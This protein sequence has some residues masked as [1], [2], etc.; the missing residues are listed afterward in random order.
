MSEDRLLRDL[1]HLARE[2]S[3]A[4]KRRLDE[5]WDRLAAGTLSAEEE[6]ELRALAAASPE[7]ARAYE[8]FRPLGADFQARVVEAIRAQEVAERAA[9]KSS[10]KLLPWRQLTPRVA[11]WGTA[12]AAA[13]ASLLMLLRPLAPLPGYALAEISGGSR[14]LR[15]ETM[16][17]QEFAP[18]DD[19]QVILRPETQVARARSLTAQAFLLRGTELRGLPVRSHVEPSGAV[20]LEGSLDG[21]LPPGTWTL[22]AVVGRRGKLPDPET[23]RSLA[24]R[25]TVRKRDWVAVRTTV[26][27]RPRAP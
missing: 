5:R 3:E 15:G 8:A 9:R 10:R 1:G 22:W 17:V 13:A 6:A 24:A 16:E 25:S 11:A 4:E 12:A 20:K 23:L 18:G 14:A 21:D 19:F 7:A 26:Q 2:E 27:V